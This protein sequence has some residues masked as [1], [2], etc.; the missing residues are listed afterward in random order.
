[1]DGA[2][3]MDGELLMD[4]EDVVAPKAS[5]QRSEPKNKAENKIE[6][7]SLSGAVKL[8][9]RPTLNFRIFKRQETEI[10]CREEDKLAFALER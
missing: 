8:A 1:M 6:I 9:T 3:L 2:G 4:G 5:F 10:R 7:I